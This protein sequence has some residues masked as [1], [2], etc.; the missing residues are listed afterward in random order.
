MYLVMKMWIDNKQITKKVYYIY[1]SF[2][3]LP[4]RR[5]LLFVYIVSTICVQS[6]HNHTIIN[7]FLHSR[8]WK[9]EIENFH[10]NYRVLCS[11]SSSLYY[12][13]FLTFTN[14]NIIYLSKKIQSVKL[15][16]KENA[17]FSPLCFIT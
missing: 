13:T 1:F 3:T 7:N 17:F 11:T 6:H 4:V 8:N 2:I 15:S 16:G 10:E 5:C 9:L 12:I 14:T